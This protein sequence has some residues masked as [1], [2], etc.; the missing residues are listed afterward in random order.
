M[1]RTL[2]DIHRSIYYKYRSQGYDH[3]EAISKF[4]KEIRSM[5]EEDLQK[6]PVESHYGIGET[7]LL[8]LFIEIII[9]LISSPS[10]SVNENS[11]PMTSGCLF[12]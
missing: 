4:P 1:G 8:F 7:S 2:S 9:T 12:Y 11:S 5:V 10:L 3:E 6:S